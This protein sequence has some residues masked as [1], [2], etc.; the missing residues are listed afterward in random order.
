VDQSVDVLGY[1]FLRENWVRLV[2]FVLKELV[3]VVKKAFA[4]KHLSHY[5]HFGNFLLSQCW[6][7]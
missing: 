4:V 7:M 1:Y 3:T 2:W 6:D 5:Q